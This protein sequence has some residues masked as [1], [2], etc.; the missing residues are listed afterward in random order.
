MKRIFLRLPVF[1]L[2]AFLAAA[3]T[4]TGGVD[5]EELAKKI[6]GA[7]I[8]EYGVGSQEDRDSFKET[9]LEKGDKTNGE[10]GGLRGRAWPA[11]KLP[12]GLPVYPD[13]SLMMS[14]TVEG[15]LTIVIEE[16]SKD[17]LEKYKE[18]LAEDGW[19]HMATPELMSSFSGM[20][21]GDY[22]LQFRLLGDEM[23]RILF[24]KK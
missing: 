24:N 13:G 9:V 2:F 21:K 22:E 17:S 23:V 3:C 7:V 11:D 6:V 20:A 14:S 8:D 10:G 15:L 19:K 18:L 16:T 5:G 4:K 12:D 1:V